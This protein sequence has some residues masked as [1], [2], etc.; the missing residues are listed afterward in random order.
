M[1]LSL[2]LDIRRSYFASL[3]ALA[4]FVGCRNNSKRQTNKSWI[5][6]QEKILL[7]I[8]IEKYIFT[9]VECQNYKKITIQRQLI[10]NKINWFR[11]EFP[12]FQL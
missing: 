9:P 1:K 10:Y 3:K 12:L 6:F 4:M 11:E 7:R 2:Y 5:V 8:V